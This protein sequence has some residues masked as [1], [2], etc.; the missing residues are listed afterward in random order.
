MTQTHVVG[1]KLSIFFQDV[2]HYLMLNGTIATQKKYGI[3]I[4]FTSWYRDACSKYFEYDLRGALPDDR[5][6][7]DLGLFDATW[8]DV[9]WD[10]MEDFEGEFGIKLEEEKLNDIQTFGEL[11]KYAWERSQITEKQPNQSLDP[12]VKTSADSVNTQATQG[13]A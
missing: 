4:A 7:A 8:S 1:K 10:I 3:P 5:L 11:L 9:D 13:H 12:I 2:R 6:V